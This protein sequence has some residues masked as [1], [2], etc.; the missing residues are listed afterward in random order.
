M[1]NQFPSPQLIVRDLVS[2]TEISPASISR[3]FGAL[4]TPDGNALTFAGVRGGSYDLV[5]QSAKPN[6]QETVLWATEAD[7]FPSDWS[8]DGRF[9][10]YSVDGPKTRWDL[11]Y[12]KRKDDGKGYESFPFLQSQ[13]KERNP[14]FSP[15]GHLL[16]F[17]S[18]ESGKSEV[19]VT[20]FPENAGRLRVSNNGGNNPCWSK[21]GK[22]LYYVEG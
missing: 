15:D 17:S 9:L 11:W 22:E 8:S 5:V 1:L 7:E 14:K 2:G 6:G 20:R 18:D 21:D 16:V 12:L 13:H 19:Y 10:I 4:W 3:Q